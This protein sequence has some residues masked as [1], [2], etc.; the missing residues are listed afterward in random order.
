M[1]Y[2]IHST[3]NGTIPVLTVRI[4]GLMVLGKQEMSKNLPGIKKVLHN[5]TSVLAFRR[6]NST[7]YLQIL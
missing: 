7:H 3:L 5:S 2:A 4:E 6:G 1:I